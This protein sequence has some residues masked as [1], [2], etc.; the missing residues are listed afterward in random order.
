MCLDVSAE[1]HVV[2]WVTL[3]KGGEFALVE[4]PA[5]GVS[6]CSSVSVFLLQAGHMW[7]SPS[8]DSCTATPMWALPGPRHTQ[9]T[10]AAQLVPAP[11]AGLQ[12]NW[13]FTLTSYTKITSK[14]PV[15]HL[16]IFCWSYLP[17]RLEAWALTEKWQPVRLLTLG[18]RAH[19][20]QPHHFPV[21]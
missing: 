12:G 3:S 6:N 10:N 14:E 20:P 13:C 11:P 21:E 19:L 9:W 4:G 18:T 15:R 17:P 1:A 7:P 2:S 8:W 5:P 16:L